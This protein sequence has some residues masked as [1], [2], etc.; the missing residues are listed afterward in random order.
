MKLSIAARWFVESPQPE[1]VPLKDSRPLL[2]I[3]P[4][5]ESRVKVDEPPPSSKVCRWEVW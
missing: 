5:S 3:A 4:V 1:P 2:Y